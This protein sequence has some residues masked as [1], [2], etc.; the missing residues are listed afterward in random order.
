MMKLSLWM[1]VKAVVE[2][3]FG[4][5]FVLMPAVVVA[6]YGGPLSPAASTFVRLCGAM[7]LASAIILWRSRFEP[8]AGPIMR[9]IVLATV[10]SNGIGVVATLWAVLSGAWNALGWSGVVFNVAFFV[11]FGYNLLMKPA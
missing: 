4:L 1:G 9:S 8:P 2:T 3:F 5:G 6:M 7:F 11:G 10:I